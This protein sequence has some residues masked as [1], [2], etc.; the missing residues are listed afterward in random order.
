MTVGE[1]ILALRKHDAE[2]RVVVQGY[3]EGFDDVLPPRPVTLAL[4]VHP[5][6]WNGPHDSAAGGVP[7]VCLAGRRRSGVE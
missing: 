6:T 4:D 2:H 5:E 1:L 3:E 7:A